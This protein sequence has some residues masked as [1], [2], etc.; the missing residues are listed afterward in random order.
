MGHW[1][2]DTVVSSRGK[3]KGCLAT[4]VE[5]KTR[6]YTTIKIPDRTAKSMEY[7]IEQVLLAVL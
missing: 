5:H 7:A 3:S 2:L 1:K 6:L 4:F